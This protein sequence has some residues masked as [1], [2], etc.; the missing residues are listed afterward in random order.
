MSMADEFFEVYSE[1]MCYA[2]VCSNL[3]QAIVEARMRER[4]NGLKTGHEWKFSPDKKFHNGQPNPC[5]CKTYQDTHKH[6]L[7]VC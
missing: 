4:A 3:P 5:P 1:G 2:N 7:F 6:Y